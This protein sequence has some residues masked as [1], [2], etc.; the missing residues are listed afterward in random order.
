QKMRTNGDGVLTL[1][2]NVPNLPKEKIK[3]VK[4][5]RLGV[6]E[7]EEWFNP[8]ENE[9]GEKEYWYHGSPVIYRSKDTRIDVIADQ[10][11]YASITPLKCDLTNKGLIKEIEQWRIENEEL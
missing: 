7:Y 3:G 1:N 5:T 2:I 4:Y 10:E 6:R 11:D 9:Q 8:K